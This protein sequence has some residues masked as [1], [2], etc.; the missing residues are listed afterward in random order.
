[1]ETVTL[2][3]KTRIPHVAQI[4]TGF[5]RLPDC[6][7]EARCRFENSGSR[8]MEL[9]VVE[10]QYRG[11]RI[12]Y[13]VMDGYQRPEAMAELLEG[14]DFYFKRSFSQERNR[15]LFGSRAEKMYPLGFN[16]H[17]TYKGSP[18][19]EPGWKTALKALRG[20]TPEYYFTPEVFEG[21]P[22]YREKPRLLFLTRLWDEENPALSRELKQE[23]A[24]INRSRIEILR[25]LRQ[26]YGPDFV[27]GLSDN[28]AARR[29]A[30]ELIAP[31]KLTE[32][33]AYLEQL[34]QSDICIGSMGLHGSIGWKNGEYVA[35]SKAVVTERLRY[36]LPGGYESGK[37]CLEFDTA[38]ECI[39]LVGE[40]MADPERV[41]EMKQRSR[42]YYLRA[43]KPEV[44][45][46]NTLDIVDGK[47][48]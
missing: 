22:E 15:A 27:G 21:V 8:H 4:V 6:R 36:T 2:S 32:R 37:H 46:R 41:Y 26:A 12:V 17:V 35:A 5:H 25:A 1:M 29:M 39:R 38:G 48:R 7:M 45:I 33:R 14:C 16:Y 3:L 9:A 40:L 13:D 44:L 19:N 20:D 11:R 23:R 30:P 18:V 42:E 28:E 24:G 10:A 31:Q 34:R 47:M 43:L